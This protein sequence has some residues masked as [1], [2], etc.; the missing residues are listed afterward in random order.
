MPSLHRGL[1]C[2]YGV[3]I[4]EKRTKK[5]EKDMLMHCVST[6]CG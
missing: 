1:V 5:K 4:F 6:N 2:F 3:A